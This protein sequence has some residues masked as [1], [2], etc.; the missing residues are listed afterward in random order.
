M[1]F[2]FIK[3]K[4]RIM[5]EN[6]EIKPMWDID[7]KIDRL[8][9]MAVVSNGW[10]Y[11]PL[12]TGVHNFSEKDKFKVQPQL[13]A[14]FFTIEPTHSITIH[15]HDDEKLKFLILAYGFLLGLYLSPAEYLC[16]HR[17]PHEVGKL[18]G[19]IL[20]KDDAEKG[21]Y[22]FSRCFDTLDNERRKLAFAIMH[23]F[24]IGQSYNYVWDR[25]DAQYKVLDSIYKFSGLSA[26]N[27]ASR[28]VILA[29]HFGIKKPQWIEL[30]KS[31][32]SSPLSRIRNELVHE[33]KFAG[34]PIGYAYPEENFDFEFVRF[35]AKLIPAIFGLRSN[36]LQADPTDRNTRAWNF[37]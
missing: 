7:E 14:K 32:K 17:I 16:L 8:H 22:A 31:G 5:V 9:R 12:E 6:I 15:T 35:N 23:W 2:G 21:I 26:E 28:P 34:R 29:D 3:E 25:F 24:L 4:S 36:F 11:P 18:T 33:A 20:I 1:E 10:I 13:P 37:S 30:D 19:V 27:H